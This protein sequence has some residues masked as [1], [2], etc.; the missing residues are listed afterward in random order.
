[1]SLRNRCRPGQSTA[2]RSAVSSRDSSRDVFRPAVWSRPLL[3]VILA[4]GLTGKVRGEEISPAD[5]PGVQFRA[6]H[7]EGQGVPQVLP[8]TPV[9][10]FPYYLIE[11]SL[12]FS[13]LRFYATNSATVGGNVGLGYRYY[14]SDLDRVF[15]ISGWY[16]ADGARQTYFQQLGLSLETY[17]DPFD[18]RANFYLPVGPVERLDSLTLVNGSAQFVGQ[19]IVYNQLRSWYGAMKGLDAE[20]GFLVPGDFGA[21][22]GIRVYG[23]GYHYADNQGNNITG[24]QARIQ[25]NIVA[26][27]DA[28]VQVMHDNY[29]ETRGFVGVAWTFGPLHRSELKQDTAFGRI[30][31]HV[32]RNYTVVA[33]LRHQTEHLTAINPATGQPYTFSH[34]SS[35]AA[36]GGTGAVNNPFQTV[37]A[38]QGAHRD[39]VFVHAGSVFNGPDA[40]VVLNPGDRIFGDGPNIQHHIPVNGLGSLLVP[41]GPTW[42]DRPLFNGSTGDSITLASNSEFSGFT[43]ANA[44]GNAIAGNGVG[45]VLVR[46][47]D[48]L[49]PTLNGMSLNNMTGSNRFLRNFIGTT[50]GNGVFVQNNAGDISFDRLAMANTGG[51]GIDI[52]GGSGHTDFLGTTTITNSAGPAVSISGLTSDGEVKFR[53]LAIDHRQNRGL[54]IENSAGNVIVTG[55]AKITNESGSTAS[56]I[57][58]QNFTGN[59]NFNQVAVA[60]ATG[61][62]GINLVNNSG[63][64]LIGVLDITSHN[65]TALHANNAGYLAI[66]PTTGSNNVDYSRMGTINAVDGTAIDVQSTEMNVHLKSVSS[67]NATNGIRLV[68]TTGTMAV[69]G[70]GTSSSGGTISGATNA[71]FL[72]DAGKVGLQWMTLSG[73]G[74]GVRADNVDYLAISST[75]I[76]DSS[77]YGIDAL[78]T[79]TFVLINSSLTG[80]GAGNLRALFDQQRSYT[81]TLTGNELTTGAADNVVMTLLGTGTGSTMNLITQSNGFTNTLTGSTGLKVDWNGTLSTT[82]DHSLFTTSGGTNTGIAI[83]NASATDLTTLTVTGTTFKASGSNSTFVR[84]VGAGPG[85]V[86][87]SNNDVEF[88]AT[89]GIGFRTSLGAHSAITIVGNDILDSTDGATGML[90]DSVSGPTS[91]RIEDNFINLANSGALVDRGIYF[92]TVNSDTNNVVRLSGSFD[93]VIRGATTPFYVPFGTTT[94][95]IIVNGNRVP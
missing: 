59:I 15:G 3:V 43:I 29:F 93:N 19:N 88:S 94:G 31:E 6:G 38:A 65:A 49:N 5:G 11:D 7:I 16:D 1:M 61:A 21:D 72:Q 50:G 91:I 53:D 77:A 2:R 62:A 28:H 25:A 90:F 58:V 54:E 64:T 45:N 36:A 24:G 67:T 23:G 79:S 76:K 60:D 37:T 40:T 34:V 30:G 87:F 39:F 84:L 68:S 52:V 46:S 35:A 80:N 8:I 74:T 14:S 13:D 55:T 48:I 9:E 63:S 75:F 70:T 57:D 17:A 18:V 85:Q 33:P 83:N 20:A 27:L 86:N 41:H 51:A 69:Y 26:G 10:L 73:N 71:V 32:T 56:A 81:Y 92:T 22:H 95:S 47:V 4:C 42:G 66:N 44:G 89:N 12:I 78:N 82:V